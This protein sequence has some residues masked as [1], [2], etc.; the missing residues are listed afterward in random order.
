VL[1]GAVLVGE[2]LVGA[3]ELDREDGIDSA[4]DG[5][6]AQL[7]SALLSPS[8]LRNLPPSLPSYSSVPP[9]LPP[10]RRETVRVS[11]AAVSRECGK[12]NFRGMWHDA[13]LSILVQ[14]VQNRPTSEERATS[15]CKEGVCKETCLCVVCKETD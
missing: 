7:P 12:R 2:V 11:G 9:S 5:I 10:A 1:V 3:A 6:V 14:K 8:L 13:I 4:I 15:A